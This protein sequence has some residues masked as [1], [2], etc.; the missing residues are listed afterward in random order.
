MEL[1]GLIGKKLSHSF[2]P[3]YFNKKFSKQLIKADYRLFELEKIDQF[4]EVIA[5]YPTLKGLNVTIPYKQSIMEYLDEIDQ[6]AMSI[7]AVNTIKILDD[8]RLKG[9]NTDAYGF[10]TSLTS[11]W[12]GNERSC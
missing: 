10:E 11:C 2:S 9:Y 1:Y 5:Q 7:G 12:R 3:S 6:E 4:S 8:N